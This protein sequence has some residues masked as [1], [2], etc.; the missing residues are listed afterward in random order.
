[1]PMRHP[2]A[3]DQRIPPLGG[4]SGGGRDFLGSG[5]RLSSPTHVPHNWVQRAAG[6]ADVSGE[7][8]RAQVRDVPTCS[9]PSADQAQSPGLTT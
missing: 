3:R 6:V 8:V 1:M 5:L 4:P 2:Q 7:V 9:D